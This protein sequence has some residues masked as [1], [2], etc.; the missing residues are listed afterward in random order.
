[1]TMIHLNDLYSCETAPVM[2]RVDH[3]MV[4]MKDLLLQSESAYIAYKKHLGRYVKVSYL[5]LS[6]TSPD[7][8][9]QQLRYLKEADLTEL[10]RDIRRPYYLS[11]DAMNLL[12][13][14]YPGSE[15]TVA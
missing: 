10:I 7:Q 11:E 13:S 3:E 12:L 9:M 14:G 4:L 15:L 2:V 8:L 5:E 6:K 1:M